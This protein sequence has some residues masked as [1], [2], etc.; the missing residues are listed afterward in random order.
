MSSGL[1]A[2]FIRYYFGTAGCIA[3]LVIFFAW[4]ATMGH[5]DGEENG[6]DL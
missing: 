3:L 2:D 1:I 6:P 4:C 5:R